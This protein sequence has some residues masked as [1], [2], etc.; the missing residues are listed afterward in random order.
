MRRVL[1]LVAIVAAV[2]FLAWW[3]MRP[4]APPTVTAPPVAPLTEAPRSDSLP[5]SRAAS[6][7]IVP[8][9]LAD[10]RSGQRESRAEHLAVMRGRCV[11][12]ATGAPLPGC[13]ATLRGNGRERWT[14][15]DPETTGADG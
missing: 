1:S 3:L 10:P 11:D 6:Q 2:G 15:P 7:K 8:T 9:S 13:T 12:A 4:S 5:A 14:S